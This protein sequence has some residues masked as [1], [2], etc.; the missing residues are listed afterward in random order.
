MEVKPGA[1]FDDEDFLDR[2]TVLLVRDLPT[3]KACGH[4]LSP[5]DF[6]PLRGMRH[7]RA[8]WLVAENA[9]QHW[10]KHRE[11][12]GGLLRAKTLEHA[13]RIGIAERQL[14]EIEAYCKH[15]KNVP[16]VAPDALVDMVVRYKKDRLKAQ[17]IQELVELQAS[18][19]LDDDK[20]TEVSR[21]ALEIVRSTSAAPHDYLGTLQDRL[22]RRR[23]AAER[24]S[25]PWTLIDPLDSLVRCVGRRQLGLVIAPW[26]RGKSNFLLWLASAYTLQ[27]YNVL[28]ITLEDPLEVVEDRLDSII[29]HVPIK[30]LGEKPKT[31]QRRFRRYRNMAHRLL[32]IYDGTDERVT[33]ERID[34]ILIEARDRGDVFDALI[35]DYDNEIVPSTKQRERRF[36]LDQIYRDFRRLISYHNLI[37]WTASQTQRETRGSKVLSGDKISEDIGKIQKVTMAI[38][39][40]KSDWTNDAIYLWVA[41]HKNDRMNVGC[42][43]VPDLERG[44]IY[45]REATYK[46]LREHQEEELI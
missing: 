40:G 7:G 15:L 36:E 29:T 18:G 27:R 42:D 24:Q 32:K 11:A 22:E 10:N 25:I 16:T 23:L 2:L 5:N 6:K 9:L 34:Q 46:A 45:D 43:I 41:A 12:I 38:S 30:R 28:Y 4:L 39:L 20:W 35:V 37:G 31:V 44:L 33:I 3:L 17:A 19:Q 1:F 14:A 13:S 8:R 21:K 26:K